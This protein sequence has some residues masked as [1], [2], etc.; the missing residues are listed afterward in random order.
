[1]ETNNKKLDLKDKKL[2]L[3]TSIFIEGEIG[4]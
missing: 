4:F 3:I 1:M 2:N